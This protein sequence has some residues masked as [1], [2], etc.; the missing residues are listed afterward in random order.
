MGSR[1]GGGG[2]GGHHERIGLISGSGTITSVA[3]AG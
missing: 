3:F 1:G 2:G